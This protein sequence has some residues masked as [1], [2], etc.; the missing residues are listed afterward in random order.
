MLRDVCRQRRLHVSIRTRLI[1]LFVANVLDHLL[2]VVDLVRLLLVQNG[3]T[4]KRCGRIL[5][6]HVAGLTNVVRSHQDFAVDGD[7][8]S[9]VHLKALIIY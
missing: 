6:G 9:R 2:E 7:P 5:L 1:L 3:D 4:L 8:L